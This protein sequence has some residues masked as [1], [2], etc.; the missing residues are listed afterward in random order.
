SVSSPIVIHLTSAD[1]GP[2][3]ID[4]GG[5]KIQSNI[6]GGGPVIEIVVD[7]GVNVSSLTIS[8]LMINGNGAEGD[9]IKIVADGADRSIQ[10]LGI[11]QV[12]VEHVGGIGL[13]MIGNVH[14]TVFDSWMNG[15]SG[16]GAGV[17]DGLAWTGGGFRKNGVA[18]LILDNGTHDMKV[19]GAYFVENTG[20]GID[21]TSG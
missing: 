14:G 7:Q 8:N 3:N 12:N 6:S 13:D 5:A 17:A 20:V 19:T 9:G 16:G 18:G 2:I 1:Q 21:A 11:N 10:N 4:F 15:N